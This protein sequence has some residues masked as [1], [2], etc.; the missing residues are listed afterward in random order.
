MIAAT[1]ECLIEVNVPKKGYHPPPEL[2]A[3]RA[4]TRKGYRHSAE[5]IARIRDK[6]KGRPFTEQHLA[7]VRAAGE[8]RRGLSRPEETKEKIRTTLK[9]Q[10]VK[11]KTKRYYLYIWYHHDIPRYVGLSCT[12]D[13]WKNHLK[14]NPGRPHKNDYFLQYGPE[15]N[16]VIVLEDLTWEQGCFIEEWFCRQFGLMC[17]GNGTLLNRTYSGAQKAQSD[18]TRKF[19]RGRKPGTFS[20]AQREAISI[21]MMGNRHGAKTKCE[22]I[23]G[24]I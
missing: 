7:N 6:Q 22:Q 8:A 13:R 15:M 2:I 4:A 21:R 3:K 14:N 18:A 23:G 9:Q 1:I 24:I 17:D 10:P 12:R 5:T 11:C 16:C 19:N 20:D